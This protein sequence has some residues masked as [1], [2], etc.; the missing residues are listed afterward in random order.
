MAPTPELAKERLADWQ[1]RF[2]DKLGVRVVALTGETAADL[3]L[4]EKGQI[5]IATPHQWDVLSRRWKQRKNVQSVA[6]FI[7]DELHLIG[8][9]MVGSTNVN[10]GSLYPYTRPLRA[11]SAKIATSPDPT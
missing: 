5:V 2:G 3:K 1:S 10:T 6:L 4:L 9:A 8:G 7:A 11:R